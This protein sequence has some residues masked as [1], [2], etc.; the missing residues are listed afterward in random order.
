MEITTENER[1][2]EARKEVDQICEEKGWDIR[3]VYNWQS[4]L[5][6]IDAR[7][8][9]RKYKCRY[10]WDTGIVTW[11]DPGDGMLYGRRCGFCRYWDEQREKAKAEKEKRGIRE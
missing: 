4:I 8:D 11:L 2:K 6:E 10:C 1:L 7:H 3:N 9:H 5:R